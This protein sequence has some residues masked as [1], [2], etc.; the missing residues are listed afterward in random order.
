MVRE[1]VLSSGKIKCYL[2][3]EACFVQL[4]LVT[5]ISGLWAEN[6]CCNLLNMK[7]D[8][9]N[10]IATFVHILL[11]KCC[12]GPHFYLSSG[13]QICLF[14]DS[15]V[16]GSV[17]AVSTTLTLFD[18]SRIDCTSLYSRDLLNNFISNVLKFR[19]IRTVMCSTE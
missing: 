14:F 7:G 13:V 9:S 18:F 4:V 5:T 1:A 10:L 17:R 6:R 11:L 2:F 19:F 12:E 3:C 16:S 15:V 8:A